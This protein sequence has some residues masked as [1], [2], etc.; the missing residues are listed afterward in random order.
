VAADELGTALATVS[1][2]SPPDGFVHVQTVHFAMSGNDAIDVAAFDGKRMAVDQVFSKG[3][4][5]EDAF[6]LPL[7]TANTLAKLC[8]E[9][10]G[11]EI[12]FFVGER[13]AVFEVGDWRLRA[14]LADARFPNY[15][16]II[17][18]RSRAPV[19]FDPRNLER[20]LSRLALL[21]DNKT[22]GV[23]VELAEDLI[24]LTLANHKTGEGSEEVSVAYG[25]AEE[26]CG[27]KLSYDCT[28]AAAVIDLMMRDE[29]IDEND[30]ALGRADA[31]ILLRAKQP[32]KLQ[33]AA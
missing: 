19:Y 2:A 31:A 4:G 26:A 10:P 22:D 30:V 27:F 3:A 6:S 16:P 17:D 11:T 5:F 29:E 33:A 21:A 1:Y 13:A 25:G 32:M 23:R 14:K 15:G 9:A 24:T 18:E 8:A 20:A 12:R 7:K 28:E